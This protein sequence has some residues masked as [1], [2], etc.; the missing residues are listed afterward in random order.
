MF[1]E[2]SLVSVALIG[3]ILYILIRYILYH[4]RID[5]IT[6][7]HVL[8]T[9]C[10]SGFGKLLAQTLDTKGIPVIAGCLTKE[11]A[12]DLTKVT[13]SRLNTLVLDISDET[14]VAQALQTVKHLLPKDAG[15][16]LPCCFIFGKAPIDYYSF[17]NIYDHDK[18]YAQLK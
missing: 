10:D 18:F 12:A 2:W 11:G 6:N 9:G 13:S 8:I 4:L 1:Q 15:I 3:I 17:F 7:R 5:N 16:W 14:S